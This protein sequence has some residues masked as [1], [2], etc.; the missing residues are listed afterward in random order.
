MVLK[1]HKINVDFITNNFA[2]G[3]ETYSSIKNNFALL[4]YFPDVKEQLE[5]K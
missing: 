2:S 5:M 1:Y 3:F 4:D